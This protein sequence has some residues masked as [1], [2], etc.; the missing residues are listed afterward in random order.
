MNSKNIKRH[1]NGKLLNWISSIEDENIKGILR[2][3]VIVTG[4][5]L[6]SLLTGDI[7]HDYDVYFRTKESCIAVAD[8]YVS[9]WNKSHADKLVSVRVNKETGKVDCFVSSKGIA[10]ESE[11]KK[12]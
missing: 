10:D 6:V 2:E 5:A 4:G 3:N 11:D 7:V 8:Y 9:I 12:K 1:L